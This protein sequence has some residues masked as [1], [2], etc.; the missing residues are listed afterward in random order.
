MT[1]PVP[2]PSVGRAVHYVS[3]ALRV[4][5]DGG[6]PDPSCWA[7]VITQVDPDDPEHIG[8]SIISPTEALFQSLVSGG[9]M[10]HANDMSPESGGT[11]HWPEIV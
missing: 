3:Y 10:Y 1:L 9:C 11:W 4:P 6:P 7:A 2:I 5:E 8:I